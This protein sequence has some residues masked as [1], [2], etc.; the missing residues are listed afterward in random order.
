MIIDN[1]LEKWIRGDNFW[2]NKIGKNKFKS[3]EYNFYLSYIPK[4]NPRQ[5]SGVFGEEIVRQLLLNR[6]CN[7]KKPGK[8]NNLLLDLETDNYLYEVK[9]R[10]YT[11][12]GT[13]G[14]KILGTPYKYSQ[15]YKYS[16]K[17]I[18]IVLVGFQEI[19]GREKFN[20]SQPSTEEKLFLDFILDRYKIRYIFCSELIDNK[21]LKF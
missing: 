1:E 6:G 9:T 21:K 16:K 14:E 4:P 19:E 5:W 15:I 10:N 13:I 20:L 12:P 11:T 2:R 7:V 18:L 17:P 3:F 8:I